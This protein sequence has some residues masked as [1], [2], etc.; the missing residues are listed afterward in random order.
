MAWMWENNEMCP[1]C[2]RQGVPD[3]DVGKVTLFYCDHEECS[4]EDFWYVARAVVPYAA[5]RRGI[6]AR[7]QGGTWKI[8]TTRFVR[9]S[10]D[11]DSATLRSR[12]VLQ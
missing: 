8:Y 3:H 1:S 11:G 4:Q 2:E 5:I 12:H 10:G 9:S 6:P 7:H